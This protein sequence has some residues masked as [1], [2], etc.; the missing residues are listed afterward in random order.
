MISEYIRRLKA[1]TMPPNI[2]IVEEKINGLWVGESPSVLVYYRLAGIKVVNGI[3][4]AYKVNGHWYRPNETPR[5]L[6]C[7]RI[8]HP[9]VTK[10]ELMDMLRKRIDEQKV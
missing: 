1:A 6:R 8:E 2:K 5:I 3:A 7:L 9:E 10:R 4:E